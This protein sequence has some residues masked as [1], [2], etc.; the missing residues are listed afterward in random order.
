MKLFTGE[1]KTQA[2]DATTLYWTRLHIT[3]C[4]G[5]VQFE[6]NIKL[7]TINISRKEIIATV[8]MTEANFK[9]L[10]QSRELK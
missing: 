7:S 4:S 3:M 8:V 6:I 2:C 1:A 9:Q 5:M 10:R